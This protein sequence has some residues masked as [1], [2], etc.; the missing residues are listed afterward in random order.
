[1]RSSDRR[2]VW[3]A[4]FGRFKADMSSKS[5]SGRKQSILQIVAADR[6]L[7]E[8]LPATSIEVDCYFTSPQAGFQ[9]VAYSNHAKPKRCTKPSF[10]SV[11]PR[12]LSAFV[13][14]AAFHPMTVL[15]GPHC[16]VLLCG[17]ISRQSL[18]SKSE[19]DDHTPKSSRVEPCRP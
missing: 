10:L 3:I 2:V 15:E 6:K 7:D 19:T 12:L 5:E 8:L 11:R 13:R 18:G 1:M 4:T 9:R 16:K 14:A 17:A